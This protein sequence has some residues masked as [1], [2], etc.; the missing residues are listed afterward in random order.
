MVTKK[1]IPSKSMDAI[2]PLDGIVLEREKVA[3][4][5]VSIQLFVP[6]LDV[7]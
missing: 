1:R 2:S 6:I 5:Y 4:Y 3:A 7:L